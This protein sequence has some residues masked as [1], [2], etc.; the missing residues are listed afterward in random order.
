MTLQNKTWLKQEVLRLYLSA[1]LQENIGKQFNISVGTVNNLLS[2]M[3]KS[4][5]TLELQ[6]QIAIISKKNNVSISQIAA[7]LRWKNT[8]KQMALDDKKMETFLN[9][10]DMLGNKHSI[11]P[12]A[13][14]NLLFSVIEIM[15]RENIEPHKLDE[16]IKSKVSELKEINNKIQ[17]SINS[18]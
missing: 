9:T 10:M 11:P 13:L 3:I 17:T 2:E 15:L 14:A 7:N 12:T 18:L 6:R 16:V 8:I 1:E 5:D 4:D